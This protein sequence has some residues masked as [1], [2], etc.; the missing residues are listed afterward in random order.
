MTKMQTRFEEL[1]DALAP[2]LSFE[3]IVD[4]FYAAL[5]RDYPEITR[6]WVAEHMEVSE[7]T[8]NISATMGS[9]KRLAK[10]SAHG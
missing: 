8:V 2:R 4:E 1:R 9:L 7:I 6:R 10:V 3:A 5:R